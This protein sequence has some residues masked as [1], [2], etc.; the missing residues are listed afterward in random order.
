M[1]R[2]DFDQHDEPELVALEEGKVADK[3]VM[4]NALDQAM[5]DRNTLQVNI[6]LLRGACADMET[7]REVGYF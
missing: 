6:R 7:S 1:R 2:L 4:Q 3:S 5:R